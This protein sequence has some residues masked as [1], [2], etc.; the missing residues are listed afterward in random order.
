MNL[1]VFSLMNE[2]YMSI[3]VDNYNDSEL[4]SLREEI[5][6]QEQEYEQKIKGLEA[7]R[8]SELEKVTSLKK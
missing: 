4:D 8:N 1:I 3:A 7:E 5:E 6:K 2:S